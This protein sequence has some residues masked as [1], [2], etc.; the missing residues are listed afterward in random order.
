[1]TDIT[2]QRLKVNWKVSQFI[3]IIKTKTDNIDQR[4]H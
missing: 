3:Y 2:Y 4:L 1:M